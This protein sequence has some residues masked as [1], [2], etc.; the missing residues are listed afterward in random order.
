MTTNTVKIETSNGLVGTIFHLVM[1]QDNKEVGTQFFQMNEL[2]K[3]N[4]KMTRFLINGEV[5]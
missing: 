2:E 1:F 4:E 3:M 5:F